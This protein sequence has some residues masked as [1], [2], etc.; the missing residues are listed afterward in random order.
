MGKI[1]NVISTSLFLVGATGALY[2]YN[3]GRSILNQQV[4]NGY[5]QIQEQI[6]SLDRRIN[7]GAKNIE[8]LENVRAELVDNKR[9]YGLHYSREILEANEEFDRTN[10]NYWVCLSAGFIGLAGLF[11]NRRISST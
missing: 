3:V 6:D 4:V 1:L 10:T 11:L 2:S 5:N 7:D 9:I 8:T